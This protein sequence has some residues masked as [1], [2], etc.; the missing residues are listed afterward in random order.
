MESKQRAIRFPCRESCLVG[1][2]NIPERVVHRG[3]LIVAG[4]DRYRVGSHRQYTLLARTLASQG[5]PAMRFDP[6]GAGDSEGSPRSFEMLKDDIDRALHE[7]RVQVPEMKEI[8]IW[9]LCDGAT[10]AAL[11]AYLDCRVT[12]LVLLNPWVHEQEPTPARPAKAGNYASAELEFW[13]NVGAYTTH[14]EH[15]ARLRRQL[16]HRAPASAET[17]AQRVIESL[18]CF[19]GQ[20]LVI[21]SE[22]DTVGREFSA[23]LERNPLRHCKRVEIAHAN[24]SFAAAAW[25]ER[26][27]EA[28]ASWLV[29]W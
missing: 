19:H 18:A 3:V 25:R 20:T 2:V 12:G 14:L 7:F 27:A 24:H 5:I 21:L 22:R 23:L 9:G 15:I 10:A 26:V 17:L 16:R 4:G 13:R 11:Y 6:R 1:I 29:S 28:T 8:V